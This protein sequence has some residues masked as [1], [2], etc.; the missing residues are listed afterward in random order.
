MAGPAGATF[1]YTM[2]D[3]L[4]SD[5][6]ALMV[7]PFAGILLGAVYKPPVLIVP[8]FELPPTTPETDQ[9]TVVLA[10][11]VTVAVY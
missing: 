9:V 4:P 6:R 2:A 1:T 3:V 11:P 7:T 10:R 8:F 5:A